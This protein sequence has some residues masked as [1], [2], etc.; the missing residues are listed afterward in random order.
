MVL[1]LLQDLTVPLSTTMNANLTTST[2]A[3]KMVR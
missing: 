1:L 3:R 2:T